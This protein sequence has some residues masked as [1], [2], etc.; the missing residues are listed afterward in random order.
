MLTHSVTCTNQ[1]TRIFSRVIPVIC[2]ISG[3]LSLITNDHGGIIDDCIITRIDDNCF[4]LVT[5]A[6]CAL[7]DKLYLEVCIYYIIGMLYCD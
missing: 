4:Y 7:K 1:L 2:F 5:N 6:A 3:T